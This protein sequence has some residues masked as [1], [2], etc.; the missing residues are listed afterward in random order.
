MTVVG[1]YA[2]VTDYA[3]GLRVIDVSTPTAPVEIG[4]VETPWG[5]EDIAV[6]GSYAFVAGSGLRVFDISIPSAP[7][8]VGFVGTPAPFDVAVARG[9]AYLAAGD[10][11]LR[12]V[13]VSTPSAP[14][15][16]GFFDSSPW[17]FAKGVASSGS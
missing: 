11:G 10:G 3:G 2:Y 8:E 9:T 5:A 1:S 6:S 14:A 4:F 13:D 17:T 15:E 12:V 16:V 7:V